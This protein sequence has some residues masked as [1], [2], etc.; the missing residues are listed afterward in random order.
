[1]IIRI[2][3]Q[4]QDAP[5]STPYK[6]TFIYEGD[7]DI[8][9]ADYLRELNDRPEILTQ[10][11][12]SAKR[13]SWEC[14]CM[15]QKCGACAMLISGKPQLACSVFLRDAVKRKKITLAPLSKFPVI[16]DLQVDRDAMFRVLREMKIWVDEKDWSDYRWDRDL[17][18]QAG[19]CLM[20]GCCL[21]V[22]PNY[23]SDG[24]FGGAA[25][26]VNAFKAIEFN[27]RNEHRDEMQLEYQKGFLQSC[28]QAL[29]CQKVC[30]IQLPLDIIQA[31]QNHR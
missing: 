16:R 22:C 8:T 31:R 4:R 6:Q 20:C 21:E 13:I 10:E 7:G 25:A 18:F 24:D 28:G 27:G 12:I 17:Q 26:L 14:S 9:V 11:G 15:E 30:P 2:I 19:Q 29:A 3:I 23:L 5:D 1:M